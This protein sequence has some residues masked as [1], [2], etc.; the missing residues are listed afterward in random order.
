LVGVVD[1]CI[2]GW[3]E[4][5]EVVRGNVK[6]KTVERSLTTEGRGGSSQKLMIFSRDFASSSPVQITLFSEKT[7]YNAGV[8]DSSH[9]T[10]PHRCR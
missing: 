7:F 10:A 6:K 4:V 3:W 8:T 5:K 9:N 2:G 1:V